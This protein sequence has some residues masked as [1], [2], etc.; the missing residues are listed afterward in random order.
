MTEETLTHPDRMIDSPLRLA[1]A[2]GVALGN[3]RATRKI[4]ACG[5]RDLSD[6]GRGNRWKRRMAER[7]G[8][9]C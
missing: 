7:K 9:P 1:L 8:A 4:L 5:H 6:R 3:M 2:M